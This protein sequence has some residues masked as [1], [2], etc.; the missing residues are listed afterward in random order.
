[1]G[2]ELGKV[3][4]KEAKEN[5]KELPCFGCG[6]PVETDLTARFVLCWKCL[7]GNVYVYLALVKHLKELKGR[8]I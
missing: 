2:V 4:T 8:A 6:K 1:M 7:S 5:K 3:E